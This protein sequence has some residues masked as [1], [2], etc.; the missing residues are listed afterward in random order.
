[1]SFV[2]NKYTKAKEGCVL[3]DVAAEHLL[4][5]DDQLAGG[6]DTVSIS[7]MAEKSI[8]PPAMNLSLFYAT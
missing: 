7:A 5:R 3:V 1:M 6:I 4:G 2:V 8:N